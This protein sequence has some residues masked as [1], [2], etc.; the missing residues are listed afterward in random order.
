MTNVEKKS[1]TFRESTGKK[2]WELLIFMHGWK[3]AKANKGS[4]SQRTFQNS[5]KFH[6]SLLINTNAHV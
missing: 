5:V 3:L 1:S 6:A 2:K 4:A